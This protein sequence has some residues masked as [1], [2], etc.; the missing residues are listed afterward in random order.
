MV[1]RRDSLDGIEN[2][3]EWH[4]R[5][6]G[7]PLSRVAFHPPPGTA[8]EEDVLRHLEG[9]PRRLF[10]LIDGTLVEKAMG[11]WESIV[12]A[13]IIRILGGHVAAGN[14][15]LVAGSDGPLRMLRGNVRYPDVAF[16]P[17]EA[18]PK[19]AIPGEKIWSVVPSLAIEVL[20]ESN[21][22]QEIERK[23]EELFTLGVLVVWIIDPPTQ[24]AK[25]YTSSSEWKPV[26]SKGNLS[27]GKALPGYR[28]PLSQ[29][30]PKPP[31]RKKAK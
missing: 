25:V 18:L 13:S 15:G 12:A 7:I 11:M 26:T 6:G 16:I 14:L 30:F 5:L 3:G 17:W 24:T 29:L 22:T 9:E 10:E 23:I 27:G 19:G 31:K 20:S 8:T 4:A 1:A 28:L 2:C 21:T